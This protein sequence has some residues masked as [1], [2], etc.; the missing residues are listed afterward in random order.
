M[1]FYINKYFGGKNE[2]K[3]YTDEYF[4]DYIKNSNLLK[5]TT[6][7][8][9]LNKLNN[10]KNN[11][12]GKPVSI[13]WILQHPEEFEKSLD[14][15]VNK[16][17]P[18]IYD[19][20]SKH[21]NFLYVGIMAALFKHHRDLQENHKELYIKWRN[22]KK[23]YGEIIEDHYKS[24]EKTSRQNV[25]FMPFKEIEK[26]RDELRDG[27]I[28]KLVLSLYTLIPPVRNDFQKVRIFETT[29]KKT[30]GS[31]DNY[32]VLGNTN[33]LFLRDYKTSEEYGT[34]EIDLPTE[35]VK[36]IKASLKE[37][38]R[39]YLFVNRSGEPYEKKNSYSIWINNIVR[40][41]LNNK[42]FTLT[43]FR[44]IYLSRP[45]LDVE[46]LPMRERRK[47]AKNMG[48]SLNAQENYV[49]KKEK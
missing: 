25:S 40:R 8:I 46:D 19:A 3:I 17:N 14:N 5:D 37:Q 43:M 10:I 23:Q 22:L 42:H 15:F 31:C 24:G 21:I 34:I 36:Q 6:K 38:P 33:K 9:Y 4:I 41:V 39:N 20:P 49:F 27:S 1:N 16:I 30:D 26:I 18:R 44:H 12:F 47:L 45:D 29:P 7:K 35:L 13:W 2:D 11:F 28:E 48:H 32:L